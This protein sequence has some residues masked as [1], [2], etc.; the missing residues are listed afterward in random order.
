MA[1]PQRRLCLVKEKYPSSRRERQRWRL[2][3]PH[4]TDLKTRIRLRFRL[5]LTDATAAPQHPLARTGAVELDSELADPPADLGADLVVAAVMD[6][7][8]QPGER[9]F[10]RQIAQP[11]RVRREVAGQHFTRGAG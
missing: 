1:E 5:S 3:T 8:I 4:P 7:A 11:R 6:A 9:R 10:L 2:P